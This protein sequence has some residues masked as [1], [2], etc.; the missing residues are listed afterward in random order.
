MKSI[1]NKNN[2]LLNQSLET[3]LLL[4]S[5]ES[6]GIGQTVRHKIFSTAD[7]WNIQRQTKYRAIRRFI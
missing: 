1:L 2:A 6:I 3:E 7:L 4:V 5:H